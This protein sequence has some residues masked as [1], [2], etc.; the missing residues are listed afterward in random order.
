MKCPWRKNIEIEKLYPHKT[1]VYTHFMECYGADC[2][3]YEPESS[4]DCENIKEC[5]QCKRTEME[6]H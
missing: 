6:G 1:I 3:F 2:P 4:T 5:E